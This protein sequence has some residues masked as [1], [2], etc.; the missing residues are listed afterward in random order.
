[1][2]FNQVKTFLEK[3]NSAAALLLT[4]TANAQVR[5]KS[6]Q[7][8]LRQVTPN[9]ANAESKPKSSDGASVLGDP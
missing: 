4:Q 3:Q 8:N 6:R 9:L 5:T 7:R 2:I 1:M